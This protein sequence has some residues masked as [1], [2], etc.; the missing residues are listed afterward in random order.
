MSNLI[1]VR[2]EAYTLVISTYVLRESTI[3]ASLSLW[4]RQFLAVIYVVAEIT[5][6][7]I[8]A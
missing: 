3:G 6:D 1:L 8:I 5:V 4:Y 7:A 2:C